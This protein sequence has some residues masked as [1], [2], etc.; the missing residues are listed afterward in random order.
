MQLKDFVEILP[1]K[2]EECLRILVTLLHF[3]VV[4]SLDR[5]GLKSESLDLMVVVTWVLDSDAGSDPGFAVCRLHDHGL[6]VLVRKT[7]ILMILTAPC[8][9]EDYK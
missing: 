1:F 5:D 7:E 6:S 8:S 9:Y 4:S 3:H 2:R